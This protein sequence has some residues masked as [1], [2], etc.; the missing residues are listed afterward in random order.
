MGRLSYK[1]LLQEDDPDIPQLIS[2]HQIPEIARYLSVSDNYFHY[3][4]NTEN[5]YFYK[6]YEND[7]W[8]GSAHLEKQETVLFM[9]ILVFPEFQRM[10]LGTKILKDIQNGLPGVDYETIE[11]SIDER[12]AASRRLFENAGFVPVSKEEEL[13]NYVY[14]RAAN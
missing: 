9:D 13:I 4:T 8:I 2:I 11:V 12:N 6:V 3:V 7:T 5:V 1:R 10:G 14:Q